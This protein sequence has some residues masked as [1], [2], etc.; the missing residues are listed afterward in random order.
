MIGLLA[1]AIYVVTPMFFLIKK[2]IQYDWFF[3]NKNRGVST[4][5]SQILGINSWKNITI[6]TFFIIILLTKSVFLFYKKPNATVDTTSNFTLNGFE[7]MDLPNGICQLSN[8]SFLIY[9]KPLKSFYTTEHSPMICWKG[10]GFV[11]Q[12]IEKIKVNNA[13]IYTGILTKDN[14][15][16]YTA[17]WFENE[18][19]ERTV[20]QIVWRWATFTEGCYPK[21]SGG[22]F[23]LVNVN[24]ANRGQLMQFIAN[25]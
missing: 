7:K 3:N 14:S 15:T 5:P 17:W 16:M 11:F 4:F 8:D 10:S 20:D 24:A 19:G 21:T 18:W 9:I 23:R 13:E 12:K 22:H 1:L 2:V 25:Y 6:N